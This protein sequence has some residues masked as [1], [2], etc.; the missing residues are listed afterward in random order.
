MR[1][2]WS[3]SSIDEQVALATVVVLVMTLISQ[4]TRDIARVGWIMY[5][6]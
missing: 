2:G 4:L 5:I 3:A 1:D 6:L